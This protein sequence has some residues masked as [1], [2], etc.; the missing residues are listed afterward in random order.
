MLAEEEGQQFLRWPLQ[1]LEIL[2]RQGLWVCDKLSIQK[3]KSQA[4]CRTSCWPFQLR[5]GV[6]ESG[7][8]LIHKTRVMRKWR[9]VLSGSV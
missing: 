4:K 6:G 2:S 1:N 8:R 7:K 3:N 5:Y 9:L